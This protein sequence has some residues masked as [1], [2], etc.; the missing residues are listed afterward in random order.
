MTDIE[1]ESRIAPPAASANAGG[2]FEVRVG[3]FYTLCMLAGGEPRG[4]V[5]ATVQSVALQQRIAGHPLDDIVVHAT[6]ADGSQATLEIQAKRTL[7]FTASDDEFVDVVGQVWQ[8]S[9][10][11]EFDAER[12]ETAVAIARTTTR[13]EQAVQEVLHWARQRP[14]A[15]SF[16]ANIRQK[17]FASDPMRSFVKVFSDNLQ[18]HGAPTDDET[19]WRL[20]RRFQVLV[21]D[22][23]SSGSDY[24]HRARERCRL[25]LA[26]DQAN[27]AGDLWSHLI[28]DAEA[29]AR[30]SGSRNRTD[31]TSKLAAEAGLR[32]GDA[33]DL[34][35]VLALLA[36]SAQLAL[37]EI[38]NQVGGVRLART[39]LI[40]E[41]RQALERAPVLNIVGPPGAGKSSMLKHLAEL[42]QPEGRIIVLRNGRIVPGGWPRMAHELGCTVPS[43]QFFNE[44]G[45]GGGTTLFIDNIDQVDDA[46]ERATVTDLLAAV[47]KSPGWNAVVTSNEASSDWKTVLP[48]ALLP[49][50]A[51]LRV[52][53]ISD[54]EAEQLSEQNAALAVLL[55][56]DHPAKTIARNLFY[57]SRMVA[58]SAGQQ[59]EISSE[60]DLAR[61]WW[62]YGGG[63]GEDAGRWARLKTLRA[64]GADILA[65]PTRVASKADSLDSAVVAELLRLDAIREEIRGAEVAFRHDVLRDWTL[66]FMLDEDPKRLEALAKDGPLPE[67]LSRGLEMAARIALESD[68]TGAR[69]QNLLQLVSV[70]TVHGSWRR[71][72]LLALPRSEHFARHLQSLSTLLVAGDARLLREMVRLI[73]VVETETYAEVFAKAQPTQPVPPG[74]REFVYP[75]GRGWAAL[76]A[77][78]ALNARGLPHPAIPDVANAFKIW[79]LATHAWQLPINAE[80]AAIL[81]EW[82]AL[83]D[84]AVR[85]RMFRDGEARPP[86]VNIPHITDAH[87]LV[88]ML[89]CAFALANP[90]AARNYLAARNAGEATHREFEVVV[91]DRGALAKAAPAEF[92]DFFLG[93]VI[94]KPKRRDFYN[95]SRDYQPFGIHEHLFMPA[96]PGRGPFLEILEQ[97]PD[98]GLRL[99]RRIVEHASDWH[100]RQ[101]AKQRVP[102]PRIVIAFPEGSK[103][104]EGD[105]SVYGWSRTP[106]PSDMTTSALMALEA[107]GHGRVEAGVA[108]S[109]VLDDVLGPDSSSLAFL[110]VA[111]DLVL[112]HWSIFRDVAWPLAAAPEVLRLDEHRHVRDITGVD[113]FLPSE[114]EPATA[115]VKRADLDARPSRRTRLLMGFPYYV[116]DAKPELTE[117]LRKSLQQAKNEIWQRPSGN[118][119]PIQGLHA[120]ANRAVRMMD[121]VNWQSGTHQGEDGSTVKFLQYVPDPD[122]QRL[123]AEK[124]A[125]V[126]AS[127]R[128]FNTRVVVERALTDPGHSTPEIVADGITWA[129]QQPDD[130]P[131]VSEDTDRDEFNAEWDRRAIVMAA[132]LAARDYQGDD[133]AEILA[134]VE[135][136]LDRAAKG[137]TRES[138]GNNQIIYDKVALATLGLIA[139]YRENPTAAVRDKLLALAANP[140]LP[141]TNA[142]GGAFVEWKTNKILPAIIRIMLASSSY[143]RRRDTESETHAVEQAQAQR[144]E[145][146]VAAELAWLSGQ[147]EE[148]GWPTL[149]PWLTRPKRY[150][151][152]P[153]FTAEKPRK[154]RAEPPDA[155]ASEQRLSEIVAHLV[156]LTVGTAPSWLVPL[157][158]H[159]M[160]WTLAA[161]ASEDSEREPEGR[162][163][164]WNGTFYDYLGILCAALPHEEVVKSFVQPIADLGDEAFH[165]GMASLLRGFD[166]AVLS[167]NAT[168]P[169]YPAA[170]RIALAERLKARRNYQ[171]LNW[172]KEF[173]TESHAADALTAMFFQ[174]SGI[175]QTRR[176]S[177]P[178]NWDGLEAVMPTLTGLLTGAGSSG[179]LAALFLDLVETSPRPALLPYLIDALAAWCSA[180]GPDTSF[181]VSRDIGGRACRWLKE[182]L[183]DGA[184]QLL[185]SS[186]VK[187]LIDSLDILVQAGVTSA[188]E[189]EELF[190]ASRTAERGSLQIA[191][192]AD[193]GIY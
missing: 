5:G 143:P 108:P 66:G 102:F 131:P 88:R 175:L 94:E 68:E 55:G 8:A 73:I 133:R 178:D 79:L 77:W 138:H 165:D 9:L 119:D 46:K 86:L 186:R 154:R 53:D 59:A 142:L 76:I 141:V 47:A 30:G 125:E 105:A 65:Q 40:E 152:L 16:M 169:A 2:Q 161:N 96:S 63:R 173:T 72:I 111:V 118:E 56:N 10:K 189:V 185:D 134:W 92:V 153:G 136:V 12:Y 158:E 103:S 150:L 20:L 57:L 70:G 24:E 174:Q 1:K 167:T 18:R 156:Q 51:T 192:V 28:V 43:H 110:A 140:S 124:T 60:I 17:G 182:V 3:A 164:S 29:S 44:L 162:P 11:P 23:E 109:Q 106:V 4:L 82:L 183:A 27:R 95:S 71:P 114:R 193:R 101:Y 13:I 100:R 130:L 74:A 168:K 144:I 139:M 188:R 58:L 45:A 123:F 184:T 177:V 7:A 132:A 190:A 166:R 159:L 33:V 84:E 112:S 176:P 26:P 163:F 157:T 122:E 155:Y 50:L 25:V 137:P 49:D 78:L 83:I 22:F 90:E 35:G 69:W 146:A 98:E 34:K 187:A 15:A 80:I 148:P 179:Y 85:P 93:G 151:Q 67:A 181:W 62:T 127:T 39:A 149:P 117:A 54:D 91:K 37:G 128:H 107:W 87:E 97:A 41:A 81:F 180:Y 31:V 121:P 172:R 160:A 75:T 116:F 14:D 170:M 135:D 115:K 113:R 42:V 21:F 104:F 64:M 52:P 61:L 6:N 126:A 38:G 32:F 19:V 129:K 191:G 147:G 145:K 89:A 36:D 48:A 99:V 171:Q 120:L